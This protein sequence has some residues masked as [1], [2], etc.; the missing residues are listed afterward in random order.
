MELGPRGIRVHTVYP[1]LIETPMPAGARPEFRRATL[2][3]TRWAP[4]VTE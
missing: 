3:E 1:G 2:A 4:G